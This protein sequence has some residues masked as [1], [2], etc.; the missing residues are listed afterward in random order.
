MKRRGRIRKEK[1]REKTR[2]RKKD[3]RPKEKQSGK[4]LSNA[5]DDRMIERN[6]EKARSHA[7][8][9]TT[10]NLALLHFGRQPRVAEWLDHI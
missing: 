2:I 4:E 9:W 10:T 6:K 1:H 5:D 8:T 7:C 3:E